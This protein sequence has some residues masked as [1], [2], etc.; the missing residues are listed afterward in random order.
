MNGH[1]VPIKKTHSI[2]MD[3]SIPAYHNG[4]KTKKAKTTVV[5][6]CTAGD[7]I[8]DLKDK[9]SWEEGLSIFGGEIRG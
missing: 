4:T 2:V 6:K 9:P 3:V 5:Q 1:V 7:V 8:W